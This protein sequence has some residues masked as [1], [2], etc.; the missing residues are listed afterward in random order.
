[1]TGLG[2]LALS[3]HF[4]SAWCNDALM[5]VVILGAAGQLG[6]QLQKVLPHAVALARAEADLTRPAELRDRLTKL[7]PSFVFNASAY[8]QVDR[9]EAE[10]AA[11]F[12]VN[13]LAVRDLAILCRDLDCTLVHFSTDYVFGLDASGNSPYD[14]TDPTGP[15][16]AYGV[17]KLAGESFVRALCPRHFILRTCGLYAPGHVNFVE[18]MLRKAQEGAPIR[19]VADQTCTPTSASDLALAALSLLESQAFGLYH[20]TNAGAS[21]WHEFAEAIFEF[22]GKDVLVEAIKSAEHASSARRPLFSVLSNAKWL[23]AGFAPLRPW[24]EAL[25]DALALTPGPAS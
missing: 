21:S 17:S 20:V 18:T 4:G 16:N 2:S 11:A 7:Q 5:N 25:A 9:A 10:P 19:V 1:V 12:A 23:D 13:A 14:E 6:R 8:A 24:R 15:I 3:F 22:L